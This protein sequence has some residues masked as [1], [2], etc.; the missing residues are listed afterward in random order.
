MADAYLTELDRAGL[1]PVWAAPR[2]SSGEIKTYASD[3]GGIGGALIT[4]RSRT[5]GRW[6]RSPWASTAVA[7]AL[8]AAVA[9]T[10]VITGHQLRSAQAS[11]GPGSANHLSLERAALFVAR[12]L[13]NPAEELASH[14]NLELSPFVPASATS[15]ALMEP[16]RVLDVAGVRQSVASVRDS[17]PSVRDSAA[18]TP[19]DDQAEPTKATVPETLVY[20]F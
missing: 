4:L 3:P 2:S 6:K 13:L 11:T 12:P 20:G 8:A 1:L 15:L 18:P 9:V 16:A 19:P 17:E 10:G 5:S 14:R 7:A